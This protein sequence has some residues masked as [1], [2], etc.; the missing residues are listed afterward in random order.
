MSRIVVERNFET[1]QTDA[2]MQAVADRERAL[3]CR[4]TRRPGNAA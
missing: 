1:P 3:A 2:D 4:R